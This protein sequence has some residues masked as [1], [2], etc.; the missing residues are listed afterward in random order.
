MLGERVDNGHGQSPCSIPKRRLR[1]KFKCGT[2]AC[3]SREGGNPGVTIARLATQT[4]VSGGVAPW[5]SGDLEA[6]E[7]FAEGRARRGTAASIGRPVVFNEQHP[8]GLRVVADIEAL[9]AGEP[10]GCV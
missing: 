6:L 10:G 9:A 1:S 4:I 3:H 8:I 2:T 5:Q 7:P